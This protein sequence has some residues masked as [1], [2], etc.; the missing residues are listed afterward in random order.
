[1][2]RRVMLP[3][4]PDLLAAGILIAG[5]FS[6]SL[7]AAEGPDASPSGTAEMTLSP[8]PP[9]LRNAFSPVTPI[10][11]HDRSPLVIPNDPSTYGS[12][13]TANSGSTPIGA[14]DDEQ[15][16]R[17][18]QRFRP[19]PPVPSAADTDAYAN[20]REREEIGQGHPRGHTSVGQQLSGAGKG[21]ALEG[22]ILGIGALIEGRPPPP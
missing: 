10:P 16:G 15:F 12:T 17:L 5:L 3:L 21:M 9:S 7:A 2:R 4:A 20:S 11:D 14:V 13:G 22:A 1:M 19:V 6:T 8:T 18:Q